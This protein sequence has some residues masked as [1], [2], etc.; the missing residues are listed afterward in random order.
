[1]IVESD[2]K[3]SKFQPV[4]NARE[5]SIYSTRILGNEKRFAPNRSE[6]LL[7]KMQESSI[8]I[9]MYAK[10][11]LDT[12]LYTHRE[13]REKLQSLAYDECIKMLLY[14]EIAKPIF[15]IPSKRLRY[16]TSLLVKTKDGLK[17]W[18]A[19]DRREYNKKMK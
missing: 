2:R 15:Q 13:K 7:N 19:A 8:N 4:L 16:W 6:Y 10:V 14:L 1:M 5:V 3:E 12:D 9:F 17:K 11:A 18:M